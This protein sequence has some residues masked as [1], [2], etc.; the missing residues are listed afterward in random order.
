MTGT[1]KQVPTKSA[2]TG[3]TNPTEGVDSDESNA[4]RPSR[5]GTEGGSEDNLEDESAVDPRRW[6]ARLSAW[7]ESIRARPRTYR[8]YRAVVGLIG[9]AVVIGG[10]ALVPLP[11]PGWVIVFVGLA[12]LATE[13]TWAARVE[14]F[15]RD[16]VRAW[17]QWMGRQPIAIRLLVGVLTFGFVALVVYGLF[18]VTGVP[19]WIPESWVPPLPGL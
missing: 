7:R 2:D 17:T 3:G 9:G 16:Q 8:I 11:G 14:R 10:L 13:F 15:A 4:L 1:G 6:V 12:V 18:V 19:S 5:D